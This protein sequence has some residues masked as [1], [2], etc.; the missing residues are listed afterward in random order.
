MCAKFRAT[1]TTILQISALADK[2]PMI[3]TTGGL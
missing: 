1:Q 2:G 3:H